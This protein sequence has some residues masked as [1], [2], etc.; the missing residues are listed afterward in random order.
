MIRGTFVGGVLMVVLL[1]TTAQ[2]ETGRAARSTMNI[3]VIVQSA[4]TISH[5]SLGTE[6]SPAHVC[7]L[8]ST[9]NNIT[10]EPRLSCT[11]YKHL[12]SFA[13]ILYQEA[14]VSIDF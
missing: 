10:K 6:C 9:S 3:G 1:S 8:D 12:P 5:V 2:A 14:I 4:C 7:R 13:S 11:A